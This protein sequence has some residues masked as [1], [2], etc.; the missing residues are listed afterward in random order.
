MYKRQKTV[1]F[2][3]ASRQASLYE[4]AD[5]ELSLHLIGESDDIR[6]LRHATHKFLNGHGTI[7]DIVNVVGGD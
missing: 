7:E 6:M 4:M 2:A 1:D 5:R 3:Q